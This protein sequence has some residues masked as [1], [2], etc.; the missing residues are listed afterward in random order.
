M[1]SINF[2]D[3][4]SKSSGPAPA[5]P[6]ESSSLDFQGGF[7]TGGGGDG[8]A[9]PGQNL[10]FRSGSAGQATVTTEHGLLKLLDENAGL[11]NT[12]KKRLADGSAV[13][14]QRVIGDDV[15]EKMIRF[16]AN[17]SNVLNWSVQSTL[18]P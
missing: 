17:L 11:I 16:R 5:S 15:M 4:S 14:E 3:E 18:N 6:S 12:L 13:T 2:S 10:P 8:N 7:A 1:N 9:H